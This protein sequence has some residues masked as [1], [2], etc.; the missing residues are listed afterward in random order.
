MLCL[1]CSSGR[2]HRQERE[3]TTAQS[4]RRSPVLSAFKSLA[5]IPELEY[6]NSATARKHNES[7]EFAARSCSKYF[8]GD[9]LSNCVVVAVLMCF[10]SGCFKHL[11]LVA[12]K[13]I[14]KPCLLNSHCCPR[15]FYISSSFRDDADPSGRIHFGGV[16]EGCLLPLILYLPAPEFSP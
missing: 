12:L 1:N 4:P 16:R 13:V 7:G 6:G 2:E 15:D 14:P 11:L 3:S 9:T 10:C 5:L 8:S